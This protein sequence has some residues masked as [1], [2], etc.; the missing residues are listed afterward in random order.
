[1]H[2]DDIPGFDNRQAL[3]YAMK[4]GSAAGDD[5]QVNPCFKAL[6]YHIGVAQLI[7]WKYEYDPYVGE[8]VAECF[9]GIV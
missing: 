1:M 3:L 6:Q 8:G 4:P 2:K 9:N 7:G 5:I